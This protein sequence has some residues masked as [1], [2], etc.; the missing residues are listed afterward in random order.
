[1]VACYSLGTTHVAS[2]LKVTERHLLADC[3]LKPKPHPSFQYACCSLDTNLD[4]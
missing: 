3:L 1:M 4:T 2:I